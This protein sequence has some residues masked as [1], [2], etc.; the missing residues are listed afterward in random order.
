MFSRHFKIPS[1]AFQYSTDPICIA[2]R[3]T[4]LFSILHTKVKPQLK[5]RKSRFMNKIVKNKISDF[6][7]C[8]TFFLL[9][10]FCKHNKES[11]SSGISDVMWISLSRLFVSMC[12]SRF[13]TT[14]GEI[15]FRIRRFTSK[16]VVMRSLKKGNFCQ[17][18]AFGTL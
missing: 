18:F 8:Q 17:N 10:K 3:S 7:H 4:S 12:E 13:C 16:P 15:C 14:R 1:S 5:S 9:Q 6:F 11:C 2:P